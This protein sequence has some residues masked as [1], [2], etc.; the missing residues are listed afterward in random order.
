MKR[1]MTPAEARAWKA[2]WELVNDAE[3]EELRAT[4]LALK[5]KQLG[6]LM[7]WARQLRWT[8]AL[9]AEEDVVRQRWIRLR[10]ACGV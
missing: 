2:R 10:K 6:T 9:A 5:L 8:E 3:R 4:P 1:R 7:T